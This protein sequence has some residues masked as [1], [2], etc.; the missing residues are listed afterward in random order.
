MEPGGVLGLGEIGGQG[1]M[2]GG[3]DVELALGEGGGIGFRI[4]FGGECADE[5]GR[6]LSCER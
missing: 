5:A 4:A 3:L 1:A 6:V 2:D